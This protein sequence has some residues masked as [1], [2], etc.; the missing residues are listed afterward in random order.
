MSMHYF[1]STS[2]LP[3]VL[4]F[5]LAAAGPAWAQFGGGGF[6]GGGFGGTGGNRSRSSSTGSSSRQYNNNSTIG[7]AMISSDPETRRIIVIT[8]EDTSQFV[9]QVITNLD[10]PKPQV[11]IKVVFM[12]VTHN[13]TLEE[14]KVLT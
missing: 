9:S 2:L 11:L 14:D 8:D 5:C 13:D 4:G 7:E 3:A 1:K 10:R 6:G 12:E